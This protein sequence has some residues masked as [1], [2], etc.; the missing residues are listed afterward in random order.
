MFLIVAH[1]F[2]I[3]G[4]FDWS[5]RP[6]EWS[7]IWLQVLESGGKVGVNLFILLSGY[8]MINQ[9]KTKLIK[10]FQLHS[11]LL[12]YGLGITLAFVLLD[13]A[14]VSVSVWL[15]SLLP[16]TFQT[17]WFASA[18][19]VLY[20]ISPYLNTLLNQLTKRQYLSLLIGGGVL[21]VLLPSLTSKS[22]ESN[23]FVWLVYLYSLAGFIRLYQQEL[24]L[25]QRYYKTLL[26]GGAGL[27]YLL[28]V[29]FDTLGVLLGQP[30]L[31]REAT[32]F[33]AQNRW[34][35]FIIALSVFLIVLE[36]DDLE[37][38]W[39]SSWSKHMFGVYLFHDHPLVRDFLWTKV[40]HLAPNL[41][42]LLFVP[43]SLMTVVL[44]LIAG[45]LL[46]KLIQLLLS[47]LLPLQQR[48]SETIEK[49]WDLLLT[50]LLA[51][52]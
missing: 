29:G 28:V 31:I 21:W 33:F 17:W 51:R 38:T 37:S 9:K 50:W 42:S 44:V 49:S 1:H 39:I 24:R 25:Y 35:G 48:L 36:W 22:Y 6:F 47:R 4:F 18:Y 2:A 46:D 26:I 27:S 19:L 3:H 41:D 15:N 7:P 23:E 34:S 5:L 45:S 40:Q 20:L 32:F 8:F 11:Q 10:V 13:L 14:P 52:L 12:S 30:V 43:Y 16:V